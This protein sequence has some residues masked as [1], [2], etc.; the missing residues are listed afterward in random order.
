[1]D[2]TIKKLSADI[3]NDAIQKTDKKETRKGYNTTGYGYQW[4]VDRFNEVLGEKWGFEWEIIKDVDGNYKTGTPYFEVTVRVGIWLGNKETIRSCVGGHTAINYAD[5][6]KGAI[7]NG[8]KKTA[9]FWGVGAKAF[10]GEIDDDLVL[11]DKDDN[12]VQGKFK[13]EKLLEQM[14]VIMKS[15]KFKEFEVKEARKEVE[16]ANTDKLLNDVLVKYQSK[17]NTRKDIVDKV[18]EVFVDDIPAKTQEIF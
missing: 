15:G 11:P 18:K 8:F 10:R 9:A 3:S 6:L 4:C 1:M 5:A 13:R 14:A 2:E 7:T 17:L 12:K 16:K